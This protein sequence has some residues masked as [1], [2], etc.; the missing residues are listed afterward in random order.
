MCFKFWHLKSRLLAITVLLLSASGILYGSYVG[1]W[2]W[3]W[4]I[5]PF[6]LVF[7][8]LFWAVVSIR[9]QVFV[10]TECDFSSDK[11]EVMLSFD[12][13]P[14]P[15]KTDAILALLEKYNMQG[16]FFLIGKKIDQYP[17]IVQRIVEKGHTIGSHSY[18]HGYT[19]DMLS[20][21]KVVEELKQ[22]EQA[23]RKATG[24]ET[25]FF[26]P[27]YG[28]TNPNIARALSQFSYRVIGWNL[29]SL[30]TII[31]D[32]KKLEKRV[33][34]RVKPGTIILLHDTAPAVLPVLESVLEHLKTNGFKTK[35]P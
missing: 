21:K 13:G 26:R 2:H 1:Y 18:S 5:L 17:E 27:P 32:P 20:S 11:K 24:Q 6:V 8:F 12:D 29:R 28:I 31:H 23:I 25:Y 14:E 19:F 10:K 4:V 7:G 33:L 3:A 30:D 9:S 34:S 15:E 22:T 16:I 35:L